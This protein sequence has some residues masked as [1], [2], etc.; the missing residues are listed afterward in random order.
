MTSDTEEEIV[1]EEQNE[2]VPLKDKTIN[3]VKKEKK[4]YEISP[5][6]SERRRQRLAEMRE[7]A[8]LVSKAKKEINPPKTKAP[9]EP[10]KPFS[11][12]PE[13]VLMK[14]EE[15]K[16]REP[17]VIEKPVSKPKPAKKK[18]IVYVSDDSDTE[19]EI[20]I[21]KP[22]VQKNYQWTQEDIEELKQRE[23]EM[24]MKHIEE[25]DEFVRMEKAMLQKRYAD[26]LKE[27]QKSQLAKFMFGGR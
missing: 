20:V 18:K 21:K 23:L 10:T 1:V 8:L 19:E 25:R 17:V 9:K 3:A 15:I 5:E 14:I 22:K 16:Q 26:K 2:K 6:E 4:K 27:V 13:E 12:Q 24:R 11:K 7:R